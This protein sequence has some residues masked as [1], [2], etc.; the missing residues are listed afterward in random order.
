MNVWLKD[1]LVV[2]PLRQ[3]YIEHKWFR[4]CYILMTSFACLLPTPFHFW[5]IYKNCSLLNKSHSRIAVLQ[6]IFSKIELFIV[7]SCILDRIL[8]WIAYRVQHETTKH[9]NTYTN[10]WIELWRLHLY[11]FIYERIS[12][13]NENYF[14]KG[15]N[16][17]KI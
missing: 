7:W 1:C 4:I 13:H 16:L 15:K 2:R 9:W 5:S 17:S 6:T 3:N 11:Y 12:K 8:T 10:N 14:Y